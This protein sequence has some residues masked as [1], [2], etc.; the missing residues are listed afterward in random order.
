MFLY[1]AISYILEICTAYHWSFTYVW[2]CDKK[3]TSEIFVLKQGLQRQYL[4]SDYKK[5]YCVFNYL[6]KMMCIISIFF[7]E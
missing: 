7:P 3:S 2:L 6:T 5:D 1:I 4:L